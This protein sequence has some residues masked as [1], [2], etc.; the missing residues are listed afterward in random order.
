MTTVPD[1]SIA[2]FDAEVLCSSSKNGKSTSGTTFASSMTSSTSSASSSEE[3]NH[4]IALRRAIVVACGSTS[5]YLK[6]TS[7][8]DVQDY[9]RRARQLLELE[10]ALKATESNFLFKM[11]TSMN[12][13]DK[14]EAC[15]NLIN[16]DGHDEV[17]VMELAHG[18][19][20]LHELPAISD[21]LPI[22]QK[23]ID[24]YADGGRFTSDRMGEFLE[25]LADCMECTFHDLCLLWVSR[26]CFSQDGRSIVEKLVEDKQ[27]SSLQDF[28]S[29]LVEA[30][31]V[32]LFQM[33]DY[34]KKGEVEHK[35]VVKHVFR[36]TQSYE[37]QERDIFLM[38]NSSKPRPLNLNEFLDL[39]LN[40]C[41]FLPDDLSYA[42]LANAMTVSYCRQDVTDDDIQDLFLDNEHFLDEFISADDDGFQDVLAMGKLQRLF[43]LMDQDKNGYLSQ[44]E[45][46]LG[47]RKF[48]SCCQSELL[49]DTLE[50][51]SSLI[52][53][54]DQ[55]EDGQLNLEEFS[56]LIVKL[57]RASHIQ[58]HH[59]IDFLVIQCALQSNSE[60]EISY[61]KAYATFKDKERSFDG[62]HNVLMSSM[63]SIFSKTGDMQPVAM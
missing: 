12:R 4:L 44:C 33:M 13:Q 46:A 32:L 42:E 41:T 9:V 18:L 53:D 2:S 7:T 52:M 62:A 19:K 58:V 57:S 55:D 35:E 26:I 56:K 39:M 43:A 59:L 6:N 24:S 14:T 27:D 20:K 28:Q 11:A 49:Q 8:A 47:I 38:M 63:S 34:H 5:A 48:V 15:F 54:V 16:D 61:I 21:V 36:F 51:S 10:I 37:W 60:R 30:R 23:T 17:G 45:L 31:F 50:N 3:S 29:S 1:D 40:L 22:A 25:Q